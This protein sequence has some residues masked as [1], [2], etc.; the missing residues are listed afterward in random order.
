MRSS[1][2]YFRCNFDYK[3]SETYLERYAILFNNVIGFI[4]RFVCEAVREV[5]DKVLVNFLRVLEYIRSSDDAGDGSVQCVVD[6]DLDLLYYTP[7]SCR[8][9]RVKEVVAYIEAEAQDSIDID[10]CVQSVY[11]YYLSKR[12]AIL[13]YLLDEMFELHSKRGSL[14]QTLTSVLMYLKQLF[15]R[16][17]T[18]FIAHFELVPKKYFEFQHSL[19]E[20]VLEFLQGLVFNEL[21]FDEICV[22]SDISAALCERSLSSRRKQRAE[23][24]PPAAARGITETFTVKLQR[25][26]ESKLSV[27]AHYK[28][29]ELFEHAEDISGEVVALTD[30]I[31]EVYHSKRDK[32][33]SLDGDS[34]ADPDAAPVKP[35]WNSFRLEMVTKGIELV[36]RIEK[37]VSDSVYKNVVNELITIIIRSMQRYKSVEAKVE[38]HF[39]L[40]QNLLSLKS[41]F[42]D[43]IDG[44][45]T[46]QQARAQRYFDFS[47]DGLPDDDDAPAEVQDGSLS[48]YLWE[49]FQY[50]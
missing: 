20:S 31:I 42:R 46:D 40:Y 29:V 36:E 24:K 10:E 3:G 25:L 32:Q 45:Q 28:L 47:E 43:S 18:F 9:F 41:H 49:T 4:V 11:D 1:L 2:K 14:S 30:R 35:E 50:W 37:R 19:E 27:L 21:S 22:S 6:I 8:Y 44:E 12:K 38:H 16:E 39:F 33:A 5:N 23:P 26:I 17:S 13:T 34:S 7:S 15:E 48:S